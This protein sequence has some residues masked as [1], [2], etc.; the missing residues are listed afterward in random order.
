MKL[1]VVL[2]LLGL[3]L[4]IPSSAQE[5]PQEPLVEE[6]YR[7]LETFDKGC[8]DTVTRICTAVCLLQGKEWAGRVELDFEYSS[9]LC[10]CATPKAK[11]SA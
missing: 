9:F 7:D 3:A 4:A 6:L 10:D 11:R 8:D 1:L 2:G 5:A